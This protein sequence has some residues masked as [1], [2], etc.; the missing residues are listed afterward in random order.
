MNLKEKLENAILCELVEFDE[1][2]LHM[3]SVEK[4]VEFLNFTGYIHSTIN[5]LVKF[6]TLFV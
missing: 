4:K 3:R 5:C 1:R 2:I 6:Q